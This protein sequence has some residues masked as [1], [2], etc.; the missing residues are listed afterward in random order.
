MRCAVGLGGHVW[1]VMYPRPRASQS[2]LQI[3][4]M[5]KLRTRQRPDKLTGTFCFEADL[6]AQTPS[7]YT[8]CCSFWGTFP[9]W[10]PRAPPPLQPPQPWPWHL[11]SPHAWCAFIEPRLHAGL[12]LSVHHLPRMLAH[13]T[14]E[15][16]RLS[17]VM[18]LGQ[19]HKRSCDLGLGRAMGASA[20]VFVLASLHRPSFPAAPAV[21]L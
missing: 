15:G 2:H 5:R 10:L 13:L 11:P 21:H 18:G 9:D 7:F 8:R 4:E 3:V 6:G 19:A 16:R 12:E 1:A 17:E 20:P 14:D